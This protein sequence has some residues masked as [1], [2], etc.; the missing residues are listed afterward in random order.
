M[1]LR[2]AGTALAATAAVIA[3]ALVSL[4]PLDAAVHAGDLRSDR[5][6]RSSG[7][8]RRAPIQRSP[9]RRA[10]RIASYASGAIGML[11][12]HPCL[13][14][15]ELPPVLA[16][17][18]DSD[19]TPTPLPAPEPHVYV[20]PAQE[21]AR[22]NL[23][24]RVYTYNRIL[25]AGLPFFCATEPFGPNSAYVIP[26]EPGDALPALV[27]ETGFDAYLISFPFE[28]F[29][30]PGT[31]TLVLDDGERYETRLEI[32][33]F[34]APTLLIDGD[35]LQIAGFQP[36]EW[37]KLLFFEYVRGADRE[38]HLQDWHDVWE[39]QGEASLIADDLGSILLERDAR[40]S[41]VAMGEQTPG[42]VTDVL[43][44]L[45]WAPSVMWIG[46]WETSAEQSPSEVGA[47]GEA[48]DAPEAAA[49]RLVEFVLL[50]FD[51]SEIFGDA[52]RAQFFPPEERP[53]PEPTATTAA[54]RARVTPQ[55]SPSGRLPATGVARMPA[56]S[57]AVIALVVMATLGAIAL[58]TKKR[59]P[60]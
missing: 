34:T 25:P 50:Q 4:L 15:R 51:P 58:A 11:S 48:G 49:A 53:T 19:A 31:W 40:Y 45:S 20:A 36:G 33:P 55:P 59:E 24:G 9:S 7:S 16:P 2:T 41:V 23:S 26:P 12:M 6:Q 10:L 27:T 37:V 29:S 44:S 30:Q 39:E 38:G 5:Y 56:S 18:D 47:S 21:E 1:N 42:Y 43:D 32:A 57:A 54:L 22:L 13:G 46:A 52:A 28:V 35:T 17:S 3:M 8:V 14:L 60:K